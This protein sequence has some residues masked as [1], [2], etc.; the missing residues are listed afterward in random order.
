MLFKRCIWSSTLFILVCKSKSL[1]SCVTSSSVASCLFSMCFNCGT[2]MSVTSEN[3]YPRGPSVFCLCGKGM[4]FHN[5]YILLSIQCTTFDASR[6]PCSLC[7][8]VLPWQTPFH[9]HL[10]HFCACEPKP[11][12]SAMINFCIVS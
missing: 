3:A 2:R 12:R 4:T 10:T 9:F 11:N 5:Q 6:S 7:A 1:R 8:P